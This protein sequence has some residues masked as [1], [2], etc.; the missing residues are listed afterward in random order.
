MRGDLMKAIEAKGINHSYEFE[1]SKK[2]SL[3]GVSLSVE[4]G[5]FVAILGHNGCGKSTLVKH[6]NALIPLQQGELTVAGLDAKSRANVYKVRRECG[7]VFQNP[8]N[9]FVSSVIKE[10]I[11]FGLENFDTPEE[12]I[13]KR[14]AEALRT[15]GME[16]YENPHMLSGGQKQRI[17]IAGVLAVEPDIIVFDEATSMLDPEGRR[18]VLNTMKRLHEEEHK[19]IIMISH[20]VEEALFADRVCLIHNGIIIAVG[21]PRQI[22]T[23]EGQLFLAG[24]L[25]P[26]AVRVYIDLKSAG[27]QLQ[28]FPLTNEELVEEICRL[29]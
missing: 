28:N 5:E 25:P 6:L 16:R 9:Q 22:L 18:E 15:V 10:D 8:D 23:D 27:V 11:A 14:I 19:T 29:K 26:I 13:P 17:A 4:Q 20:Y 1:G 21:T 3:N 2:L 12:E 7:M 24:L